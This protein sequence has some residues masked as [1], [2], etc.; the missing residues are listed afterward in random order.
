MPKT[1]TGK[2]IDLKKLEALQRRLAEKVI[3]EDRFKQPIRVV[4]GVDLAFLGETAIAAC[5]AVDYNSMETIEEAFFKH[6]L[7]FPYIPG[8]LSFREGPAMIF[9]MRKLRV[10]PQVFL[11]N[12]HG[13]AHPRFLGCA[14]QVGVLTGQPTIG[15]AQRILCGTYKEEPKEPGQWT[16]L[17]YKGRT[18]GALYKS[19]K[20]S[21]PI[22]I[23]PGH[24]TTL[25]TAIK[26]VKKCIRGHKLPEPLQKAHR[27]ANKEKMRLMEKMER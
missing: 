15:V 9:A 3:L 20:G 5:V 11:I 8:F 13:I 27:Q 24:K 4:A 21:K 18:V 12:A 25:K 10:K 17:T 16:T 1:P 2:P 14:S 23:S 19:K 6:K 7:K 22:I 26:I